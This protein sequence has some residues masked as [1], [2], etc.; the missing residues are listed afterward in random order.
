MLAR[1]GQAY[2]ESHARRLT[3]RTGAEM[4][5]LLIAVLGWGTVRLYLGKLHEQGRRVFS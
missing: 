2:Y 3:W 5:L 1:A 4:D